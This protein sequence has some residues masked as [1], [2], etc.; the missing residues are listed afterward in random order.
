MFWNFFFRH[1]MV[2]SV[3][4]VTTRKTLGFNQIEVRL[5]FGTIISDNFQDTINSFCSAVKILKVHATNFFT[6]LSAQ[7]RE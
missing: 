3:S 4:P 5:K 7:T 6:V 2:L 1:V